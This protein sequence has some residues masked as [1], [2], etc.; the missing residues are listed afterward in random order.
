MAFVEFIMERWMSEWENTVDYNLSESGV[1]PLKLAELLELAG[2]NDSF[3]SKIELGYPQT[4]GLLKL[5]ENIAEMYSG[6]SAENV[7]VT[8]G[9]AE[10]NYLVLES[11][12]KPGDEVCVILPN[13]MQVHG[14]ALNF[15]LEVRTARLDEENGWSLDLDSLEE[16]V[17]DRTRLIAVCNPNNPTGRI[18]TENE[19][20]AIIR[21]AERSG[22]WI[23]SDEVYRGAERLTEKETPS[24][25]GRYGKVLSQG[26]MSKAYGLPGLRLGWTVGPP[27]TLAS[28]WRRH[29]YTTITASM[30]SNH[31]ASLALSPE[32]RP[33]LLARTREQIRGGYDILE[34]WAESI[35]ELKLY[36]T[37][38]AAISFCRY[39]SRINSSEFCERLRTEKSCLAVPGDH[40]GIDH[41]LRLSF[42]LPEETLRGG[43]ERIGSLFADLRR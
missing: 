17:S 43:L 22:A 37:E 16:A 29:E 41:S 42:G 32:V 38:A 6:A 30:L 39:E 1:H 2:E 19:M 35:P 33:R 13:Y 31:L 40:F 11:L 14:L 3:L 34:S 4:N 23:L 36:P 5:R 28:L 26:S 27:K 24:F 7:L 9:A 12:F 8:V 10:A 21:C 20:Q 15:G 25:F 18:L